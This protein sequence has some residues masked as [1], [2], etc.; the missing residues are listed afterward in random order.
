M[1]LK[2]AGKWSAGV[3]DVAGQGVVGA[4]GQGVVDADGRGFAGA[5]CEEL[6]VLIRE[7]IDI[8]LEAMRVDGL[9]VP[10][11]QVLAAALSVAA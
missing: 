4:D 9:P 7:R 11:S 1:V 2:A 6:E 8:R 3:P 5:N 10:E